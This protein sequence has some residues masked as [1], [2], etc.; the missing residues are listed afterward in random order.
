MS[1]C[2]SGLPGWEP[3]RT[4]LPWWPR[5]NISSLCS[6]FNF[7]HRIDWHDNQW[8]SSTASISSTASSRKRYTDS[9]N[10]RAPF[11][12]HSFTWRVNY[13]S[14]YEFFMVKS[15]LTSA[16]R[17]SLVPRTFVDWT[18]NELRERLSLA[19]ER[20]RER[21]K[22]WRNTEKG[23]TEKMQEHRESNRKWMPTEGNV[24]ARINL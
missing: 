21:E 24:D 23:K 18:A 9:W 4:G 3:T 7:G 12:C 5:S 11:K 1:L 14:R 6:S 10:I 15:V 16:N 20:E 13:F 2:P 19:R 8:E 22:L 17:T